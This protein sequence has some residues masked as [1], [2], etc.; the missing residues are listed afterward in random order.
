M[1]DYIYFG[2]STEDFEVYITDAGVYAAPE[3][4]YEKV[5]VP[6]R[7]GDL[8]I[9]DNKYPNIE[10]TYPAVIVD[11]FDDNYRALTA[12]L[13][14]QKGYQRLSD[15]FHPEEFYHATF[16]KMDSLKHTT[17]HKAGTFKIVFDRKPQRFLISGEESVVISGTGYLKNP[18]GYAALPLIEATGNGTA[19]IGSTAISVSNNTGNII[20]DCDMQ[21]AYYGSTNKNDK[22]TLTNGVFPV[23]NG[24]TEITV[25]GFT[26]FQITPR[27]WTL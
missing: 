17:G 12:Y 8:L 24:S 25:T 21:E 4:S 22:L 5:N 14:S 10:M 18:T 9:E 7:N 15:S 1:R 23:L 20:I 11:D 3:R 6:G 16:K 19:V 13:L 2:K 26:A 27:W